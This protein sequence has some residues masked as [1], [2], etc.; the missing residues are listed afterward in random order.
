MSTNAKEGRPS[1][2]GV[3]QSQVGKKV[4]TGI[5]GIGLTLFVL[6]HM[7]GNLSYFT[8][9][10]AY[11]A[12]AHFLLG[13]GPLLYIAEL[14]LLAFLV[15]HIVMGISIVRGKRKARKTAYKTFK[16]AGGPSK[17][18]LSSRSMIITGVIILVFLVIH[19]NS[20]KFGTYYETTLE[21]ESV[22][23]LA[24][25]LTEKFQSPIYTFGYV[26]VMLLLG[27][28]LR[29]GV[30]S[31]FQSLGATNPRLTPVIYT[32]GALVGVVIAIGFLILPLWIFFTGGNA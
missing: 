25:L 20:F 13:L 30:W 15:F 5:T 31:A 12:Y 23:D 18:S 2:T 9:N 19:L 17:Q 3:W 4:L 21:G 1:F 29:H 26:G 24:R 22:R 14:G 32:V 28:H 11:N 10:D 7:F 16:S 8:G 6:I 27:F